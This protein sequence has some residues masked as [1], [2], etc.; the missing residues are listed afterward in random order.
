MKKT[1]L[2]IAERAVSQFLFTYAASSAVLAGGFGTKH[3]LQ[4]S[5]ASA[6]LSLV[7]NVSAYLAAQGNGPDALPGFVADDGAPE[8]GAVKPLES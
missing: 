4:I 2:N 6:V 3:D 1:I 7:K 8:D 5:A